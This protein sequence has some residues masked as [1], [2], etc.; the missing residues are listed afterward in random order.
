V[1]EGEGEGGRE[2][3]ERGRE[4]ERGRGERERERDK[5]I[6]CHCKCAMI[7]WVVYTKVS[8]SNAQ[9]N[10][11]YLDVDSTVIYCTGTFIPGRRNTCTSLTKSNKQ[12][13]M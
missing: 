10:R 11:R 2:V 13:C 9:S 1:W 4:R 3:G 8:C 12:Y 5:D 6:S 7:G